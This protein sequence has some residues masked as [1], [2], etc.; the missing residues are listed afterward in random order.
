M[1]AILTLHRRDGCRVLAALLASALAASPTPFPT[2]SQPTATSTQAVLAPPVQPDQRWIEVDLAAQVLRLRLGPQ[3]LAEFP[4][5]T[6]VGTAP[7]WTTWPGVYHVQQKIKGP[8]ENVPGVFV[9]DILIYDF[10][11]G[12]GIHSLPMD[13]DGRVLDATLGEPASGG[14]V[15]VGESAAVYAFARLGTVVWVH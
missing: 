9:S 11:A 2:A 6:G 1:S 3:I 10:G 14:C 13:L 5:A 15:R 4:I 8:I 7:E 12:V